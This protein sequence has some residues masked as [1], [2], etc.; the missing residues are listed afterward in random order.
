VIFK[1]IK[2]QLLKREKGKDAGIKSK[3]KKRFPNKKVKISNTKKK[4]R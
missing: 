3:N 2:Y 1:K 4:E